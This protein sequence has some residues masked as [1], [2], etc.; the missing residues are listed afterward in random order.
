MGKDIMMKKTSERGLMVATVGTVGAMLLCC[1]GLPLIL[2]AV[3]AVG[4]GG[5]VGGVGAAVGVAM[6]VV[7]LL[8]GRQ[9]YSGGKQRR[10][11]DATL[12]SQP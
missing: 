10:E 4:V 1:V 6:V 7:L 11:D 12:R 8:I 3:A 2:T 5:I 9:R